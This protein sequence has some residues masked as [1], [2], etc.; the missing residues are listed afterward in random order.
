[1]SYLECDG[2]VLLTMSRSDYDSLMVL[3]GKAAASAHANEPF[4]DQMA[5]LSRLNEGNPNYR[6]YQVG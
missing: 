5:L 6:P 1:M 3:L 4:F 2:T